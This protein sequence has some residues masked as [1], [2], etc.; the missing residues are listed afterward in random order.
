MVVATWAQVAGAIFLGL[1]GL[2]LAH[3]YRRQIRLKLAER[4]V[5]AYVR[6]WKLTAVATPS[7]S[8]SL[9]RTQRQELY[10]SITHWYYD[11][12]NGIFVPV[13]TRNLFLAYRWNLICPVEQIMPIMI[14]ERLAQLSDTDAERCRSCIS[15]RHAIL[16]RNQLKND[17][18]LHASFILY[19]NELHV[20]DI[21]FLKGCG[22]PP[23]WPRRPPWRTQHF[24]SDGQA[25]LIPCV[26]GMCRLQSAA[27]WILH[28]PEGRRIHI[29]SITVAGRVSNA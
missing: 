20:D 11:D 4:Q 29:H 26:C 7:Q 15:I 16:L 2:W 22:C 24:R 27:P 14:A 5:D 28:Y 9:D 6:L 12:G 10:D 23:R 13:A 25:G 19:N 18:D 1:V 8:T 21:A 3:N 17:L